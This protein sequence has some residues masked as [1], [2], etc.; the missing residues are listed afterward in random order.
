MRKF[1][2]IVMIALFCLLNA[3]AEETPPRPPEAGEASAANAAN[4]ANA[5]IEANIK[6]LGDA[7]FA[8][9]EAAEKALLETGKPAGDALQAATKNADPEVARRARILLEKIFPP[10]VL[11]AEPLGQAKVGEALKFKIRIKNT[12][13]KELAAVRCLDGS[14]INRRYPHF[15]QDVSNEKEAPSRK[16]FC[17][18]CNSLSPDDFVKLKPGEE[19]DPF[20]SY[21]HGQGGFGAFIREYTPTAAGRITVT[22]TCDYTQSDVKQWDGPIERGAQ[23]MGKEGRELFVLVPK[24]KLEAKVELDVKE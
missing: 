4:T 14:I 24:I 12:S 21:G 23:R 19:F 16:G 1:K 15:S 20:A 10:L 5:A 11:T 9:R 22:F 18:N 13:E 7:E 2:L 3:R 8:V 17:G 6:K